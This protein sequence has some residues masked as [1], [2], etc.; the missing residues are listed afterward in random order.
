M[1][2][3]YFLIDYIIALGY[4]EIPL[5]KELINDIPYSNPN[6]YYIQRNMI[7]P[8]AE[9][10]FKNVCKGTS[11]FKLNYKIAPPEDNKAFYYHI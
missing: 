5:I 7:C 1:L 3:D 10:D 2:I 4:E 6:L 8:F 9:E 11:I